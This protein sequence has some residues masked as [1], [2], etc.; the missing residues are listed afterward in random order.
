MAWTNPPTWGPTDTPDEDDLNE[1]SANLV[2]L[3]TKDT[4]SVYQS[5]DES[6]LDSTWGTITWDSE[7]W[8]NNA[9]HSGGSNTRLACNS[10]GKYLVCFKIN[11][12][13]STTG[14]R[15]VRLRKNSGGSES[16][17]TA[18][19][20]WSEDGIASNETTVDGTRICIMDATDYVELFH[21]QD[22]GAPLNIKSGTAASFFQIIQLTG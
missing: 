4:A 17:G 1:L 8:D 10:D 13:A 19:G 21:W 16:G 7:H 18:L 22:S 3:H 12:E 6:V 11:W 5:A 15:K 20:E 14:V 2:F 9:L